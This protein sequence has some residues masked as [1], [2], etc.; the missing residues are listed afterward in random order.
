[1]R[2]DEA[3][4]ALHQF[5]YRVLN[6]FFGQRV[7]GRSSLVQ[8][9][10][11]GIYEY[12]SR[13]RQQLFFTGRQRVA[14]LADNSIVT[15]FQSRDYS[16][17]IDAFDR[18]IEF[19]VGSIL[20]AVQQVL[21][22]CARKQVR[23][24]QYVADVRMQPRHRPLAHV[25]PVDEDA[26]FGR[27]EKPTH[28]IDQRRFARA[29]LA[30]YRDVGALRHFKVEIFE[31]VFVT[32]GVFERHVFKFDVAAERLPV[33]ALLV[34]CVAVFFDNFRRILY[35]AHRFG[36]RREPL[37]IDLYG[38]KVGEALHSPLN[39][40]DYALRVCHKHRQRADHY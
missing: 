31:N 24:L 30:H 13:K 35:V 28:E 6:E 3:R 12:G 21:A 17:G 2:Y 37:D 9:E 11:R 8:H 15:F 38:N 10:Y 18:R 22:D 39:G 36:Q 23:R 29:R 27:L 14:A 19:F 25:A 34:E 7:Y 40:I 33:F 26:P 32:V 5:F 20:F 1:M 4:S 16:F